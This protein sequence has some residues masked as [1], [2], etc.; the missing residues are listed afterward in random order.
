MMTMIQTEDTPTEIYS[1]KSAPQVIY[2]ENSDT[3]GS[4]TSQKS[5]RMDGEEGLQ[6]QVC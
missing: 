2:S 6:P 5:K 4:C 3:G 1:N